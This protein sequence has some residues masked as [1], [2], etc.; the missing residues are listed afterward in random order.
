MRLATCTADLVARLYAALAEQHADISVANDAAR[1]QPVFALLRCALLKSIVAFLDGGNRKIDRWYARHKTA[2]ADFSDRP[3]TFLN[4][5]TPE[6]RTAL[7]E[8]LRDHD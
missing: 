8:R 3:E 2:L 1:M 6:D 4:V 7:E 5:N